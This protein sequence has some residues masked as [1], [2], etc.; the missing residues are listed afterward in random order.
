MV[1]LIIFVDMARKKK[2][3][4]NQSGDA[5]DLKPEQV[6]NTGIQELVRDERTH[7]IM[8]FILLFLSIYLFLAFTSYL[9]TWREDQ[10]QVLK[11][12]AHFLFKL[13]S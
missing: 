4:S 5:A 3:E 1:Q 13:L 11:G 6:E 7:K 8:G 12:T 2:Q 10:D 9:F